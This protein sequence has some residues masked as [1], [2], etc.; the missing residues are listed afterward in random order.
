MSSEIPTSVA[1]NQLSC[2]LLL[3][4]FLFILI[5]YL[6]KATGSYSIPFIV[7]GFALVLSGVLM[8]CDYVYMVYFHESRN[9]KRR[10]ETTNDQSD[11][12]QEVNEKLTTPTEPVNQIQMKM[13]E[14]DMESENGTE[15]EAVAV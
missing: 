14:S 3:L 10:D 12:V 6:E 13:L 9:A 1:K 15:R 11:H 8:A 2:T 5:G 7:A 4:C